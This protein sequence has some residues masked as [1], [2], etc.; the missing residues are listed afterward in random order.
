MADNQYLS[1]EDLLLD[2]K[3]QDHATAIVDTPTSFSLSLVRQN[4]E[5]RAI[6]RAMLEVNGNMSKA[7]KL[8]DVSRPTL[9]AL[10]ER[11]DI[12]VPNNS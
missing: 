6:R 1:P 11:L 4:A 7:A 3:G 10:I 12:E 8:L 2:G 5:K 9:Y